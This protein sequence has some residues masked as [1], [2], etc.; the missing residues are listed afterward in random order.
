M[1]VVFDGFGEEAVE[2][3][4]YPVGQEAVQVEH[5]DQDHDGDEHQRP[6]DVLQGAGELKSGSK[7]G[8]MHLVFKEIILK[9]E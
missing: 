4:G 7:V 1:Q 9:S 5:Q 2:G 6:E 3:R 8:D